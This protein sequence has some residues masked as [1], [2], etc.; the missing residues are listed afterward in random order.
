[1]TKAPPRKRAQGKALPA[2]PARE[3]SQ[4][5]RRAAMSNTDL[6]RI[7]PRPR[8]K[9]GAGGMLLLLVIL[10]ASAVLLG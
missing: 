7:R 3:S 2:H 6:P 8:W 5:W 1:M 4:R 10:I 9:T